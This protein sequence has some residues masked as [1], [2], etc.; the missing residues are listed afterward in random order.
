M[1]VSFRY[2]RTAVDGDGTERPAGLVAATDAS[3]VPPALGGNGPAVDGDAPVSAFPVRA[4]DARAVV[5]TGRVN[6]PAV[7]HD[8]PAGITLFPADP[9]GAFV[10]QGKQAAGAGSVLRLRPDRQLCV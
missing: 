9:G 2:D 6:S 4:A 8:L 10:R 7:D 1:I 3:R 5:R